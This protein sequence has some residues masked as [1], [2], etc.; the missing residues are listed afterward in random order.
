MQYVSFSEQLI[1]TAIVSNGICITVMSQNSLTQ[2]LQSD[3]KG[4]QDLRQDKHGQIWA[5]PP[6]CS[7]RMQ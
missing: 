5:N 3:V 7:F 2:N 4:S 1:K 6:C